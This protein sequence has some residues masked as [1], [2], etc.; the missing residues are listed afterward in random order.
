MKSFFIDM[1]LCI[2]CRACQV[3]CKQWK[4]LEAEPTKNNGSYQN[5]SDL[6]SSTH[7]LVRFKEY[8]IENSRAGNKLDWVFF[9]E[10]CRHCLV[11]SCKMFT[12]KYIKGAI[13]INKDHGAV[14]YDDLTK[15][16]DYEAIRKA[17]PYN[18]PRQGADGMLTKC[19]MCI[20]R[21]KLDLLPAC[22]QVCPSGCMSF[23]DHNA[24]VA[25]AEA[26][27]KEVL[28]EYPQANLGDLHAVKTIYLFPYPALEIYE[29][30][31]N[32]RPPAFKPPVHAKQ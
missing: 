21:V 5:P 22:V 31:I 23:G 32:T 11:P 12:D 20:D 26:R 1:T 3:A 7:K 25:K 19:N 27:L 18:I 15:E 13:V 24:M 30:A 4:N 16:L 17:C 10:Q 8:P 6:T 9:P 28:P 2:A 29:Y 14:L